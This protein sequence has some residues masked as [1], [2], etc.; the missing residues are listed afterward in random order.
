MGSYMQEQW[1]LF[2]KPLSFR[3]LLWDSTLPSRLVLAL[4]YGLRTAP[5]RPGIDSSGVVWLGWPPNSLLVPGVGRRGLPGE[6][7][8]SAGPGVSSGSPLV[9]PTCCSF[10]APSPVH[11]KRPHWLPGGS[12]FTLVVL[13]RIRFSRQG[14][15]S[16]PASSSPSSSSSWLSTTPLRRSNNLVFSYFGHFPCAKLVH[17]FCIMIWQD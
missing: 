16:Q 4:L 9:S 13:W 15:N 5:R 10:D 14:N 6:L 2:A 1:I 17:I 11:H 3:C 7:D 8:I 12:R